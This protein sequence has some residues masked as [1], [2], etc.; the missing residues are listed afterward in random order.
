MQ[1]G[2]TCGWCGRDFNGKTRGGHEQKFCSSG[3]RTE[4]HTA[5]RLYSAALVEAG[6]LH[7]SLLRSWWAHKTDYVAKHVQ[8]TTG[9][10][11]LP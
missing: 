2:C 11:P 3:C 4:Y 5:C 10:G 7:M 6:F 1:T 8:A 9:E